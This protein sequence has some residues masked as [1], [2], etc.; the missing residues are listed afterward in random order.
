MPYVVK[1]PQAD[2]D[3]VEI[4]AFVACDTPS[5]ADRLLDTINDKCTLLSESPR[6]GRRRPELATSLHSFPVDSYV[7]FY[8]PIEDGIEV[9]RVIH[10]ARD[11]P[12]VFDEE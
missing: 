8:R 9:V 1:T 4:W 12:A 5:A 11:I 3:L 6:M 2:H 10:A 7:V